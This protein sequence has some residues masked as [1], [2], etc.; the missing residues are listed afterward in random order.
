MVISFVVPCLGGHNMKL[1]LRMLRAA[2]L[3]AIAVSMTLP[4]FA[5]QSPEK[6]EKLR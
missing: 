3:G 1:K 2:V 4:A 6:I 5:Q